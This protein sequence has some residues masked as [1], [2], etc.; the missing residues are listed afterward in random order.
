MLGAWRT[1]CVSSV[2]SV[3]GSG[4]ADGGLA[5][6]RPANGPGA[7]HMLF[8]ARFESVRRWES[9]FAGMIGILLL[10]GRAGRSSFVGFT[11]AGCV[12]VRLKLPNFE[13]GGGRAPEGLGGC[14]LRRLERYCA[15]FAACERLS[16]A[17]IVHSRNRDG[18]GGV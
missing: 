11:S 4:D 3:V 18:R 13:V 7:E 15:V 8:F 1:T 5:R 9:C 17:A 16:S 6:G 14:A 2:S 12:S 10:V